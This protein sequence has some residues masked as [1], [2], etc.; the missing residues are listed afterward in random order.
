MGV[1]RFCVRGAWKVLAA[2]ASLTG[3]ARVDASPLALQVNDFEAGT[4]QGWTN[5]AQA[6]D[7]TNVNTGGPLGAGDNFLRVTG[8]GGSGA[9][10]RPVTFNRAPQWT[11]N[12]VTP[13]VTRLELDLKNFGT[14]TLQ[15]RLAMQEQ[16]GTRLVST[17]AFALPAD[18]LWHHAT[19][20][21]DAASLTRSGQTPVATALTRLIELRVIHSAG[22]D[23][24]GDPIAASFGMDNLRAVPEPAAVAMLAVAAGGLVCRRRRG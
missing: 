17:T 12:Y 7:P 10:S 9:G 5:G 16:L 11:G 8:R 14:A 4:T 18:G 20:R 21:L 23:F 2:V 13:A 1:G 24:Q 3:V 22:P 6:A 15:M 19:F